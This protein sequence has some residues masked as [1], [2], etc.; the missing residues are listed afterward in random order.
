MAACSIANGSNNIN[1][2]A[3]IDH[4]AFS[5]IFEVGG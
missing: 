4:A 1:S 3:E 2:F 5:L